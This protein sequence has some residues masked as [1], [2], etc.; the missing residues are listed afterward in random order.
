MSARDL[1]LVYLIVGAGCAALVYRR[2]RVPGGRRLVSALVTIP[3]WPL[4][5]PFVLGGGA[6]RQGDAD[7]F[8]ARIDR[9][10]RDA[11]ALGRGTPLATMLTPAAI[12]RVNG[13]VARI[14]ERIAELDALTRSPA[15]QADA[16]AVR[17]AALER[18]GASARTLD[19]AR[20]E[21]AALLRLQQLRRRDARA[22]EEIAAL[23]EALR[24]QVLLARHAG[25]SSTTGL[26]AEMWARIEGA[27][28]L[29][30]MGASPEDS[31]EE[32]AQVEVGGAALSLTSAGR[33][34][35]A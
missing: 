22:L 3:L 30:E 26:A 21:H 16:S 5:A 17:I 8:S 29:V 7:G 15:Y 14:A 23:V 9:A 1:L 2:S 24:S 11:A 25:A 10:L 28:A 33:P 20:L 6:A 32:R 31:P 34:P 27:Q 35:V 13:E 12:A 19:T 4:W 18:A